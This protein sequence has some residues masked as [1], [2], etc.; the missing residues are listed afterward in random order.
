MKYREYCKLRQRSYD[1]MMRARDEGA[2]AL[3][4]GDTKRMVAAM[5]ANDAAYLEDCRVQDMLR[6]VT[7]LTPRVPSTPHPREGTQRE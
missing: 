3:A 1:R 5:F 2:A 4:S 6:L 7:D